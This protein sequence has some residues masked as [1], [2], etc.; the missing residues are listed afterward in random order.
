M[1]SA[2]V[3]IIWDRLFG[4]FQSEIPSAET[5]KK[6]KEDQ[7]VSKNK[8]KHRP[9]R[10]YWGV[11]PPIK[12]WNPLWA[13]FRQWYMLLYVLLN[14]LMCS[15][16]YSHT[17]ILIYSHI[18][19]HSYIFTHSYCMLTHSHAH[20]LHTHLTFKPYTYIQTHIHIHTHTYIHTYI[21]TYTHTYIHTYIQAD[22]Q[23]HTYIHTY[24]H[25]YRH[26]FMQADRHT[27]IQA[28]RQAY[29]HTDLHT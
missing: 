11:L 13:N 24:I 7:S 23:T 9:G 18:L 19:I 5:L 28:D 8:K 20:T 17:Y 26:T 10:I 12:S 14:A 21:L 29:I 16:V 22:R 27:Y 1:F 4:T 2:A 6:F 25:T 3:L 15:L